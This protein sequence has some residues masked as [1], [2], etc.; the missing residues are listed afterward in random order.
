M[1]IKSVLNVNTLAEIM[2][3]V[4]TLGNKVF[5]VKRKTQER[6]SQI[7]NP[8]RGLQ[9]PLENVKGSIIQKLL[10]KMLYAVS[11][12]NSCTS[13]RSS[14]GWGESTE[15]D[16]RCTCMLLLTSLFSSCWPWG[17]YLSSQSLSDSICK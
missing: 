8:H 6:C 1:V 15:L 16:I 13:Q 5:E 12:W 3:L 4:F 11:K 17:I 9:R 10:S 7:D 14:L 2:K